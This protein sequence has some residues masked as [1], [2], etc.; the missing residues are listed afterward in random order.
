M[1]RDD[2]LIRELLLKI[3]D[4]DEPSSEKVIGNDASPE[5]RT[6]V[7]YHL[8]LLIDDARLVKGLPYHMLKEKSWAELK[9]TWAGNDFLNNIRDDTVW[10]KTKAI[11]GKVA[12]P[13]SLAM[14]GKIAERVL[15]SHLGS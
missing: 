1:T 2:D 13:I 15:G 10:N 9:L 3:S 4:L 11:A 14:I 12:G 5:Y 8:E 6:K 7:V